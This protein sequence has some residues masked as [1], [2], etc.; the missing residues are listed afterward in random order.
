MTIIK[1]VILMMPDDAVLHVRLD[2]SE[3]LAGLDS[4][5]GHLDVEQRGQLKSLIF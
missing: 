1:M 4:L 5:L 3:M 2:N